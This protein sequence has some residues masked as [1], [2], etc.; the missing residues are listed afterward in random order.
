[1]VPAPQK[2]GQDVE[3]Q[4]HSQHEQ[5]QHD[6]PAVGTLR[7]LR[8]W[9]K[10]C[11]SRRQCE[12]GSWREILDFRS[13]KATD[14]AY[15]AH[16]ASLTLF[17]ALDSFLSQNLSHHHRPKDYIL[18]CQ[19]VTVGRPTTTNN[20]LQYINIYIYILCMFNN[21]FH[22]PPKSISTFTDRG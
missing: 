2:Q 15:T 4:Q 18:W 22:C 12:R 21:E 13:E 16:T 1:M 17:G 9:Q 10:V 14:A 19:H 5:D 11:R 20:K 3:N 8:R 6:Q 7:V